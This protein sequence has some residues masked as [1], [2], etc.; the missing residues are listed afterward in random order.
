MLRFL[1]E[2]EKILAKESLYIGDKYSDYI[3]S[4][5]N[6]ISFIGANWGG[7]D[8]NKKMKGFQII[9]KLNQDSID[10]LNSLFED[11]Y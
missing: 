5:S 4:S 6:K 11:D 1:L 3:A 9:D 2:K 10:S 7:S 8:F